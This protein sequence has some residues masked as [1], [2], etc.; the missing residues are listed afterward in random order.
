MGK[1]QLREDLY[2][3]AIY[4]IKYN[5]LISEVRFLY[6]FFFVCVC[7][8]VWESTN[9]S[10]NI[11]LQTEF[12]RKQIEGKLRSLSPVNGSNLLQDRCFVLVAHNF[13][14]QIQMEGCPS[15]EG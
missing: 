13:C 4:E 15:G 1:T 6:S 11:I 2:P 3:K 8:I 12:L 5:S 9:I 10:N 7:V 14:L